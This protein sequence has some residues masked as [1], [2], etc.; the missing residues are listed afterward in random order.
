MKL[1]DF[2]ESVVEHYNLKEISQDGWVY[3]EVAKGMYGLPQAGILA[4]K[5]L[6]ERLKD[7]GYHQSEYTPGLWTHE[8]RPICFTLVVD[9]FGVKYVGDEHAQHLLDLVRSHYQV[10]DDFGKEN[11]GSKYCGITLDWDYENRRVHL[12]MPGYIEEALVRFKKERPKRRQNQPHKHVPIK[13]GQ[14]E[15]IVEEENQSEAA[16]KEEKT[17]VQQ[18]VGTFLYYAR[19]VDPTML[20][21]LSAIASDQAFP[22]KETLE[23]VEQLLEYA[24]LQENAVITYH[25]SDMVLA[26]HSDASYLSEPRRRSRAGGH[27]SCQ[28]TGQY[29]QITEL[30]S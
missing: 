13:Y 12:S 22:T 27:F 6:E 11:Q 7:A 24:A 5:L 16:T 2:H 29:P 18:V 20:V 30:S 23:K 25:A 26:I 15:D 4:Q 3:V 1:T 19:A 8:W 9:D 10:T 21:A 14:K 28:V 17:Y